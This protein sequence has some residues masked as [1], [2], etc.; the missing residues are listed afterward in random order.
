VIRGALLAFYENKVEHFGGSLVLFQRNLAVAVPNAASHRKPAWYMRLKIGG[1]AGYITRSTKL[2][3]YEDAYE[4]AKG[5]LFRLQQA[6]RLGH[7]L[8]EF[9]F[10]QHWNDWYD[11]NIKNKAWS[12]SR[13][14]WHK[15]YAAR[16]FRPY[17]SDKDGKSL[18]LNDITPTIAMSYWDW[19]ISY[20]DTDEGKRLQ[21]YNPKRR[22]AKTRKTANVSRTPA[23]KTLLMEQSALN[24]IFYDAFERGRM[25]QT[26]KMKP[27]SKQRAPNRRAGFDAL[28]YVT[29]VRNLRS[30]RDC[31]GRFADTR[32]NSWHKLQRQQM[33]YFVQFLANTGLRVGEARAMCWGDVKFDVDI[34][35]RDEKLAEIRVSSATKKGQ[36]RYVQSQPSANQHL[37][38]WLEITPF[39]KK[40]DLVWFGQIQKNATKPKPF[41][42]LNKS[43]QAI[44]LRIPYQERAE[45]LLRDADGG[46][47][48]LYSLRHTYAT[49]RLEK[50]DVSVYDLSLNMGCKV[51]QI[52]SHYSHVASRQRRHEITKVKGVNPKAKTESKPVTSSERLLSLFESGKI[53]EE[54]LLKLLE[55]FDENG[56]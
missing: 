31:V 19:R 38:K 16:Y 17:F 2:T 32:V 34:D 28:E 54:G 25:Q 55:R 24:Q 20:W 50:G 13:Q 39:K 1:R 11:R 22:G 48:S 5:E 41:Q 35:G 40:S 36:Q 26:F 43:F 23:V 4:F 42:D 12:E 27:P 30:Y 29:L 47:R 9:T 8:T 14:K 15:N 46:K 21:E 52:E 53:S 45:G 7:S 37:K 6:A 51:Q 18:L 49:L 10:E 44:L 3:N 33:Y 56:A